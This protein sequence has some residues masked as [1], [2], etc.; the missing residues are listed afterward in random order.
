MHG[1]A[2][3]E[4][5]FYV[6]AGV[7]VCAYVCVVKCSLNSHYITMEHVGTCPHCSICSLQCRINNIGGGD[8]RFVG[9]ITLCIKVEILRA[10][11]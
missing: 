2:I 7:Y 9:T 8:K 5:V 10:L 6:T 4:C 1:T 11:Y 3:Y